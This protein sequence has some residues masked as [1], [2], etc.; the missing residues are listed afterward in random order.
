MF[1]LEYSVSVDYYMVNRSEMYYLWNCL[2][3]NISFFFFF[4]GTVGNMSR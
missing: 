1:Y 4:K 3:L 2:P